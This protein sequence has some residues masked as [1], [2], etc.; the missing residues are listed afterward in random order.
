M[1]LVPSKWMGRTIQLTIWRYRLRSRSCCRE[2]MLEHHTMDNISWFFYLQM[3]RTLWLYYIAKL[4]ELL[5]TVFLVL[6]KKT[7]Q[8]TKMHIYQHVLMPTLSLYIVKYFA[9]LCTKF[10]L[11]FCKLIQFI[12]RRKFNLICIFKLWC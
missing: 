4:V 2:G 8:I 6:Q 11:Q 1:I 5:E 3:T 9:G 10:Q 7:D 12:C